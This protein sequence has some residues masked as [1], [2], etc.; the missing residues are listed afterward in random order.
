MSFQLKFETLDD[1][2]GHYATSER[3]RTVDP[4]KLRPNLAVRV[5]ETREDN[6]L[7]PHALDGFAALGQARIIL[8]PEIPYRIL[9][10]PDCFIAD[11]PDRAFV[12]GVIDS[13]QG[14]VQAVFLVE[15][16][17]LTALSAQETVD[18]K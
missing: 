15:L 7:G 11:E 3:N 5:K 6:L 2:V 16:H 4:G 18:W 9:D 8:D 12:Q 1:V 14:R 17:S 10:L 13:D